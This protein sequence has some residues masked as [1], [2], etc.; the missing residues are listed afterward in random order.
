MNIR[1]WEE[2]DQPVAAGWWDK[3]RGLRE[4]ISELGVDP[5]SPWTAFAIDRSGETIGILTLTSIDQDDKSAEFGIWIGDEKLRG[6]GY[7]FLAARQF[8]KAAC[9]A[10]GLKR[11]YA[12]TRADNM[13]AIKA[14]THFGFTLVRRDKGFVTLEITDSKLKEV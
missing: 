9:E 12:R 2:R 7:G 1:P 13:H 10:L 4:L 8:L 14:A 11:V 6:R 3:D 5:W